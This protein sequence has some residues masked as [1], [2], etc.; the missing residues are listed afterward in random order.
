[1]NIYKW[2]LNGDS[3][4]NI[5][6]GD[7]LLWAIDTLGIENISLVG[8]EE[9]GYYY[10]ANGFRFGFSNNII[11]EIGIDLDCSKSKV[12]F[13]EEGIKFNFRNK[14][15]HKI[16]GF[17]NENFLE[18]KAIESLDNQ[19]LMIRLVRNDIV[20]IFEVHEGVLT[21]IVKSNIVVSNGDILR[22]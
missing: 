11:D 1:M 18:W 14:K 9:D 15:I 19:Y 21:K 22:L 12:I 17:L 7:S 5:N 6:I 16:L 3:L 10:M 13:K 8:D 20:F 4:Y 2:L